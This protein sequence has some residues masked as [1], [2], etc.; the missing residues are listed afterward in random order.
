VVLG[1]GFV[2]CEVSA[3]ARTLGCEVDVVAPEAEP[4]QRPLGPGLGRRLRELHERHGVRFHLGRL[5]A[6]L[7]AAGGRVAGVRLD[8]GTE[9]PAGVVVEALGGLPNTGFL[10]GTGLDLTDGVRTDNALRAL[11]EDGRAHPRVV[12]LGDVARFPNPRYG[13]GP[14]RVEHWNL[15]A[16]QARRAAA[17]LLAGLRGEAPDGTPFAPLPSFWS[18]QYQLSLQCFGAPELADELRGV[19]A[20]ADPPEPA[21]SLPAGAPAE[22]F[23]G[24][25]D[26]RLVAAIGLVP[27]GDP[28]STVMGRLLQLRTRLLA[29]PV[30]STRP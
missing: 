25:R 21:A 12:A 2:G 9:L 13:P 10:A 6:R 17:T 22:L 18:D 28:S 20:G 23:G 29:E 7:L 1:A 30:L 27:L 14:R 5:P 11:G 15:P 4:L 8:D 24:Y 26:G 19:P 3:T 16:E